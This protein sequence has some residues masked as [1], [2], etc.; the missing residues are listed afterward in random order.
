MKQCWQLIALFLFFSA[1]FKAQAA[2]PAE[3]SIYLFEN[4]TPLSEAS[5]SANG[6]SY[7][8]TDSNGYIRLSLPPGENR[9]TFRQAEKELLSLDLPLVA[10]ENAQMI[11]TTYTDGRAPV[12]DMQTSHPEGALTAEE[13]PDPNKM[14]AKGV[15]TGRV[16]SAENKKPVAGARIFLSGI[17]TELRTAQDGSFQTEVPAGD[18]SISV[19]HPN[20]SAQVRD[21][22]AVI[23]DA[24]REETFSLTPAGI[25]LPEHV[26]LEPHVAG[27][28]AAIVE[29]QRNSS[30]VANVLGA[31]QISRSGDSDA[32]GALR[33]AT[34]LT[35]VGGKFIFIRGLGERYS[36]TML[37]G[38]SIP[39]PDPTRRVVPLDLFPTSVIDS[40][41]IQKSY[42]VDRPAEF[43]GGT[44]EIRTK[45]IP[46]QFFF[47][48]STQM[49]INQGVTFLKGSRYKGGG[50]DIFG[51]D[52][53]TREMPTSLAKAIAGA[54]QLRPSSPVNPDG[55]T[56]GE[57]QVL[58][59]DLSGKIA[60]IK[61]KTLGPDHRVN[62]AMG[63][64]FN[65]GKFSFGY[66][67]VARW[68]NSW[69]TQKE[70]QRF[71]TPVS[72]N[73]LERTIDNKVNFTE[74]EVNLNGYLGLEARYA[75]NHRL[76]ANSLV[77]R[78]TLDEAR[79][80][81]GFTDAENSV[82]RRT[83]L[84]FIENSLIL[85]QI[86]GEHRWDFLGNLETNWLWT[87]ANA[88]RKAPNE[89][90]F[91][92]DQVPNAGGDFFLSRRTDSNQIIFS[93]LNDDDESIRLDVKL[94][95]DLHQNAQ[96][97]LQSGFVKR[98]KSRD[99][100]I[101][102]FSFSS[103]GQD[104]RRPEVLGLGSAE[105][106]FSPEFI[107]PNGFQLRESTQA[108]D[109]STAT[110]DLFSYYGQGDI[111]LFQK[112]RITGGL[113][114]EDNDQQVST[115]TLFDP[116]RSPAIA[117]LVKKDVLPS[118]AAIWS[119]SDKQQIRASFA[120]TVSRPDFK[121]FSS[122]PFIDPETDRI[123]IGNPDLQQVDVKHYDVRWEYYFSPNESMSIGGF[124]KTLTNPIELILLPGAAGV[125]TLQNARV[126]DVY[127]IEAEVMKHLDFIHPI[128][129]N[130]FVS[131][132]YTWS[133][134][135]IE[136][137]PENL[138]AQ[139]T[140]FRPLQGH[141]PYIFNF[142][143]GYD[144]PDKGTMATLLYNTFGKRIAE[145][146]SL[147]AP[148]KFDQPEHRVDFVFRQHFKK[149]FSFTFNAR[150]LLDS[151]ARVLQGG[152]LARS[153]SR[154]REFRMGLVLEF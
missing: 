136:L 58:G 80:T 7:G 102:R 137:R 152:E 124:W 14:A 104:S 131:T 116:D 30:A 94:P 122:A 113:R 134:S 133:K 52:D 150:N 4:G 20:F 23:A 74:R 151:R 85:G 51:V 5:L 100:E 143:L 46:D 96:L 92:F 97:A 138:V 41:L 78:Q 54:K 37:N 28:L 125:L 62:V 36:S 149:N 119:I 33:R 55:F 32:A 13:A 10:G 84:Q 91:R 1:I 72:G 25:E 120:K 18:Y 89:Q 144:D 40:L 21:G 111:N 139:T 68:S 9:L 11:I 135:E 101:R 141:S 47:Q 56:Q 88:S 82:V 26:V 27:S 39:S 130:V 77:L 43:A 61:T 118:V 15:I 76:H 98:T 108:T 115:F 73:R 8:L 12:I 44:V 154:G 95:L 6:T 50:T 42:S 148:D 22:V 3:L 83:R 2:D 65:A 140:N 66:T 117:K 38:A 106:I 126:A 129:R 79:T 123:T 67:T 75:D 153:F 35:L 19:M 71:F 114:V 45:T 69:D 29:E 63:D 112:V 81:E 146:G 145:V 99:S 107:G 49:G 24:T 110:Q 60:D 103:L 147:G 31:E 128:L 86:G 34:G 48:L 17:A 132:N 64:K 109:N 142:Q 90:S 59:Q 70:I 53:G 105:R 127:G 57:L 93:D 87:R 16:L 121:E